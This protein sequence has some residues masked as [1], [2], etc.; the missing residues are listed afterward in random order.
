MIRSIVF[1]ASALFFLS[2]SLQAQPVA[3]EKAGISSYNSFTKAI[4]QV[5]LQYILAKTDLAQ[6]KNLLL[7]APA[8]RKDGHYVSGIPLSIP[9][10]DEKV[11]SVLAAESPIWDAAYNDQFKHVKTYIL[12]DPVSKSLKGRITLTKE[13]ISGIL[14][15]KEGSVY[16]YPVGIN[17]PGVHILYYT[18]GEEFLLPCDAKADDLT[19][20]TGAARPA[21]GDQGRR[22]Y[23]LAVAATAEYTAWAGGQANALTHIAIS[24]NNTIAVF[25]RELNISFTVLTPNSIIF[26]NAAS[27]PYPGGNVFLDGSATNANQT[28]MDNILG[29]GA[30]DVGIVFNN[31]WNRGYVPPPFAYVCDAGNKAK[32][33]AGTNNGQGLNPAAGPQGLAFDFTVIHELGHMFGAPHSYASSIGTCAVYPT[34]SSAF[35]PGSGST[36]MG[37]GG[38]ASCNTYVNY[39]QHYFHTGTLEIIQ[40]Y[41]AGPGSC[42][43]PIATAN[44]QPVVY[45]PAASYTI[46]VS[47]PFTL[48]ATGSDAD[49]NTLLYNWEQTDAG[50]LTPSAPAATNTAGPNFRSFPPT[51]TGSARTFP[52]LYS[53]VAGITPAYEVLPSVTRT[54][55]FRVTARDQSV[56]GGKTATGD[57]AV[58][59]NSGA[60]PF[61]VT[62]QS[63]AVTWA[64][65][66]SQ[67]VSWNVAATNTAPVNCAAVDIL[68]STDGGIS[69]PYTLVSNTNNDGTESITVPNLATQSGRI[70]VQ[71]VNNIFFNI[72]AANITIT[73][74]CAA[75]GTTITPAADV[76][77]EAGSAS[78][79]LTLSPQYGTA[80]TP[81]GTITTGSPSSLLTIYNT[82]IP[83]CAT[84]GFNGSSRYN[85]HPFTV[86][87]SGTYTLTPSTYGLVYNLYNESFDAEYPC[88]NF[89]ASNTTTGANP[90]TINPTVSAFLTQGRKYVLV[91]GTFSNSFPALP[92]AY[93]VQ[94][95]TGGTIYNSTPN[96]GASFS[97]L[98]VVVDKAT[99]IIK[100][101]NATSNLSNSTAYP[102][103][104]LYQ[105]YG[106]SYF[107]S[108]PSLNSFV[109]NDF[110]TFKNAL[111]FNTGYCGD[112]SKNFVNVT[113]LASYTFTGNGN[114]NLAA[115]WSNNTIPPSPLPPYS[116]ININ[117]AGTGVCNLNVP[118]T[119]AD[120]N[121]INVV[122]GKKFVI[123]GNLTIEN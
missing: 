20:P 19:R 108:A 118:V 76:I 77:A 91:A 10:P 119:I 66:S 6:L 46:P 92:H 89:I 67:T 80:F 37:Y 93:S 86:T 32:C 82:S 112:L 48:T 27:D 97:Y 60:G 120:G 104:A 53:I 23:R 95:T 18:K 123:L 39:G 29:T 44:R 33:A 14:F 96:P 90:T 15:S 83:S 68:L 64:A 78:L 7:T 111:L 40:N 45:L 71:A 49:G 9:L 26:T 25:S 75:D 87:T 94:V 109:G 16:L 107:N 30:Y 11:F 55:H 65:A 21:A 2:M 51:E 38:D 4:K 117:P 5:P 114:W 24:I 103:G 73:S 105:V 113:A 3:W 8:E 47:T 121:Q 122:A 63:T 56:L 100:S 31:G 98:Y 34:A 13:G 106:L 70:K 116:V 62:S 12:S 88:N 81:A 54:M 50:F 85:R 72:N 1:A 99:N 17:D 42:V 28:A 115:N 41:I 102:G 84:Y 61:R 58:N 43:Q 101:I 74:A 36:L 22:T 35:E 110:N 69:Y 57:V 79:N 52:N 59:F